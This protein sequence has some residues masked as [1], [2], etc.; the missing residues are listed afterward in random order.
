MPESIHNWDGYLSYIRSTVTR[1]RGF[2][3]KWQN[4]TNPR[5]PRPPPLP[6]SLPPAFGRRPKQRMNTP[7]APRPTQVKR[8][9]FAA[10]SLR[11]REKSRNDGCCYLHCLFDILDSIA[12][13]INE[14]M[15]QGFGSSATIA[16]SEQSV[17]LG[18]VGWFTPM[19]HPMQNSLEKKILIHQPSPTS[20]MVKLGKTIRFSPIKWIKNYEVWWITVQ[21]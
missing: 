14:S 18:S 17:P 12:F 8:E 3:L 11:I 19:I 2:T 15:M 10:P 21:L 7:P 4:K 1:Q 13:R 9:P 20:T 6:P 5:T 16:R